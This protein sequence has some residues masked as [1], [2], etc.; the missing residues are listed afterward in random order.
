MGTYQFEIHVEAA[1][2]RVFDLWTNLDRMKEWIGGVTKVTDVTGPVGSPGTHYTVWFGRM[3]SPTEVLAAQ[4]PR[5]FKT[6]FGSRLLRGTNEATFEAEGTGTRLK[7]RFVTR[8]VISGVAA[9]VFA[10][11]SYRG[12]FRG[13]LAEFARLA[14]REATR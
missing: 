2:E 3:A 9:R 11:G 6:R 14:E 13:E 10:T 1:P 12:S 5:L 7:Q 4:R 8:G